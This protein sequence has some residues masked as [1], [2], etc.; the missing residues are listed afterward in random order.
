MLVM[1]DILQN[2]INN[3]KTD[4]ISY[5]KD[6]NQH[7]L[8]DSASNMFDYKIEYDINDIRV[9][10]KSKDNV[11]YDDD[12]SIN[13]INKIP[14]IFDNLIVERDNSINYLVSLKY[15]NKTLLEFNDI[16]DIHNVINDNKALI[17]KSIGFIDFKL[18]KNGTKELTNIKINMNEINTITAR[19]QKENDNIYNAFVESRRKKKK[20]DDE[21]YYGDNATPIIG[22]LTGNF[23]ISEYNE[24]LCDEFG[25]F[26]SF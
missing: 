7:D 14:S 5:L 13:N 11:L 24:F 4:F 1:I 2:T 15:K 6:K 20:R 22:I 19:F 18:V 26:V 17:F 3:A 25:N 12:I 23:I 9:T 10:L 8:I 16:D 21:Y